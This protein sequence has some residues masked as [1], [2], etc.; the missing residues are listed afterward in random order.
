VA[1]TS[2]LKTRHVQ[3]IALP[4]VHEPDHL[5]YL[6]SMISRYASPDKQAGKAGAL[7]VIAMIESA[8]A[9][10]DIRAIAAC[11]PG[12]LDGLLVG[13]PCTDRR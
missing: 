13:D 7:K 2:Q 4:K 11:A 12:H 10:L 9:L 1:N 6:V 5:A 3:A 8:R